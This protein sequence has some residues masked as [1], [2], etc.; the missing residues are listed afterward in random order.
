MQPQDTGGSGFDW[1]HAVSAL[2]GAIFGAISSLAA[3]FWRVARIEPTIRADFQH[4]LG[5][6]ER[7][8]EARI[9]GMGGHYQEYFEGI[10]R[11]YD[12]LRL[13]VEKDFVRRDDFNRMRSEDR[14]AAEERR[15]ENREAFDRLERKID[16]ILV[17]QP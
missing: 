3:W 5:E 9:D 8:V 6:A 16:Q 4:D 2:G 1:P 10:R 17:R 13:E 12:D 11:Q 7:R 14:E 15:K